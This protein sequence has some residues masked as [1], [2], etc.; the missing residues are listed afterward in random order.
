MTKAPSCS[1]IEVNMRVASLFALLAVA[2]VG[3]GHY[4]MV[5][6]DKPAAKKGEE[7]TVR[8][9]F[10][11]P[12]ECQVFDM[13]KPETFT[14]IGPDGSRTAMRDKL[15]EIKLRGDKGRVSAYQLTFTPDLRGDYI[16]V[17][18]TALTPI[19]SDKEAVIDVV[20]VV[21]HVQVQRGWDRSESL[22]SE[23]E[24]L[25]RPYGLLPSA[26]FEARIR[27]PLLRPHANQ[28][29][30]VESYSPTP[31]KDLP[32]DEFITR[33]MK[34]DDNGKITTNLPTPGWWGLTTTMAIGRPVIIEGKKYN[35]SRRRSTFWVHVEKTAR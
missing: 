10:G 28:L 24:P 25:T 15:K 11:H 4:H 34:T 20:K 31:P 35:S 26:V 9:Q 2:S 5:L 17:L 30:E 8:C 1:E 21:V 19:E 13:R 7:V 22:H 23:W 3:E 29:V 27:S 14:L 32:P 33:T 12:Y 18:T 6:V 16:F